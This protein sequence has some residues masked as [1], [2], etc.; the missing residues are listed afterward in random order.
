MPS[1]GRQ[2]PHAVAFQQ[3][4]GNAAYGDRIVDDQCQRLVRI[5]RRRQLVSLRTAHRATSY[6]C[7]DVED[8]AERTV[9][10]HGGAGDAA[11]GGDLRPGGLHHDL[12]V[13]YHL[14]DD[15]CRGPVARPHQNRRRGRGIGQ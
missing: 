11:D 7:T 6:Q 10:E 1:R 2:H 5:V 9:A 3:P 12:A 14:V 4:A 13:A 15:Q 8:Q